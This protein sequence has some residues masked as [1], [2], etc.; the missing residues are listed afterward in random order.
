M[1]VLKFSAERARWVR[2]EQWHPQQEGRDEADGGY[3][4]SVPYSD[5]RELLGDVLRFGEDVE[6][7]GPGELRTTRVQR[8]LLASAARYA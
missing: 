8:A 2:R 3:V 7:V 6:V 4:L 1:A 5:D